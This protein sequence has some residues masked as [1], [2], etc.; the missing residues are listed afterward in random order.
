MAKRAP[1]PPA[2][3][4]PSTEVIVSSFRVDRSILERFDAWVAEQNVGRRGPKLTRLDV[5]RGLMDWGADTKPNWE[6]K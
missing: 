6:E 3:A 4:P 5:V 1:S 2:L